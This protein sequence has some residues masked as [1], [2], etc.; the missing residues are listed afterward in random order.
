MYGAGMD[1]HQLTENNILPYDQDRV[2]WLG[3]L[4][5]DARLFETDDDPNN[6]YYSLGISPYA[7][8]KSVERGGVDQYDFNIAFNFNDRFYFGVTIGAYDVNYR[9]SYFYGE[10]MKEGNDYSISSENRINGAGWDAKFGFILRP[11]EDSPLRLGL[12]IHTPTF[13]KLT[14]TT[15]AAIQSNIWYV[16]N[17]TGEEFQEHLSYDTYYEL[18]DKDMKS[19][20]ELRTPWTYNLS[21]G[22][23]VGSNLALGAEYEYQ[24]YSKMAFY[25]P[26]GDKV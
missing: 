3:A 11:M 1:L 8:Y 4:G 9:K 25:Y 18:N 21:I 20:F 26:E 6:P 15:R 24:D 10:D 2:G 23:T 16:N 13:Y 19:E 12:A 22:Y 7:T 14:Y 5:W 17:E